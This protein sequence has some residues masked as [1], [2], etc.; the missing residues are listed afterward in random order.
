MVNFLKVGEEVEHEE[1]KIL[2]QIQTAYLKYEKQAT[3]FGR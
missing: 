3:G 1:M 2:V